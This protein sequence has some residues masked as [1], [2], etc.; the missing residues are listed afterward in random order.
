MNVQIKS[1]GCE[2][3]IYTGEVVVYEFKKA[4][5]SREIGNTLFLNCNKKHVLRISDN[6]FEGGSEGCVWSFFKLYYKN[7][8]LKGIRM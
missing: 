4:M 6:A 1:V 7:G 8:F 2:F 5:F 3:K